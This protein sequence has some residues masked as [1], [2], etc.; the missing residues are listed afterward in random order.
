MRGRR[1]FDVWRQTHGSHVMME[2]MERTII[3]QRAELIEA[4]LAIQEHQAW[5]VREQQ[6]ADVVIGHAQEVYAA[7]QHQQLTWT[8]AEE[9]A[10][11]V[12]YAHDMEVGCCTDGDCGRA[13]TARPIQ[14]ADGETRG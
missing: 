2:L 5:A 4:Q 12:L 8:Q 13:P 11:S 1:L 7:A 14:V 3:Q 9:F 10:R 6:Q